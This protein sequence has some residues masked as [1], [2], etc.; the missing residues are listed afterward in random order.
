MADTRH[1]TATQH[2]AYLLLLMTA[3][4]SPD[5]ALPDDDMFLSRC[6]ALDIR[7]WKKIKPIIMAFWKLS[8]D[9]KWRQSRL[10]DERKYAESVSEKKSQAGKAN[11]LKRWN[12]GMV[13]DMPAAQHMNATHTHTQ[14]DINPDTALDLN[15]SGDFNFGVLGRLTAKD[16]EN[17]KQI[18]HGWDVYALENK[19]YEFLQSQSVKPKNLSAL[20]LSRVKAWTGGTVPK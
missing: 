20:W 17:A 10:L 4:R 18:A 15:K 8:P 19:F 11:A 16:I 7:N 13:D 5:C 3:W 9:S 6:A 12:R 14:K 2:G 1:L